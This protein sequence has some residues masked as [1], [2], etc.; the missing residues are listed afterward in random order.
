MPNILELFSN[1][2]L[3]DKEEGEIGMKES[4]REFTN[5]LNR[6]FDNV[7]PPVVR[8][9][10]LF[11]S[12]LFRLVLGKKYKYYMKFKERV[13]YLKDEEIDRYYAILADTFIKRQT[14][15]NH[16]CIDYILDQIDKGSVVLDA[17]GGNG[18]LA[19]EISQGCGGTTYLL[20]VVE[21]TNCEKIIFTKGSILNIPFADCFFDVVVCTHT[22]E[23]IRDH[24]KAL[25]ELRRICK[26]KLIIVLPKQREYKYT[27]DLHI[28]FFPYEYSVREFVGNK[29]KIMLIGGD[30]LVIE[31][32]PG[33]C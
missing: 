31:E 32:M 33:M 29:A 14:D 20:D 1:N 2:S 22:L 12:L 8:D 19:K 4:S 11:M 23:H 24:K 5:G 13:P 7:L 16:A 6:I 3:S 30:W 15:C 17:G 26:K 25:E 10:S 21:K 18:Y 27:F 28:H 9:N